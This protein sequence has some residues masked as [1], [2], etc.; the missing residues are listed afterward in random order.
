[1][2][3]NLLCMSTT[4]QTT[5]DIM[6][7]LI[8]TGVI[9]REQADSLR[10]EYALKQQTMLNDKRFRLDG[11][12]RIRPEFRN[13]YQQ[14]RN[15]TT[16]GAMFVAQRSRIT[17]NFNNNDK[18][19]TCLS[20]QDVRVWGQYDPRFSSESSLQLFEAWVEPHLSPNLSMRFGRQ[21]LAYDNQ[22]LFSDNN[23]RTA[24]VSYDALCMKYCDDQLSSDVVVAYNQNSERLRGTDYTPTGF[25]TFKLLL[26]HYL[27]TKLSPG[28]SIS[29]MNVGDAYQDPNSADHLK[30]RFTDGGRL[31]YESGKYYFTAAA[32]YQWGKLQNGKQI[33]AWYFQPE[34]QLRNFYH[35]LIK[36][37]AE[38]FS[39]NKVGLTTIEDHSFVPLYG[40]GHSFNGALDLITKFPSD[41][42]GFGLTNPYLS[43]TYTF[44]PRIE[45]KSELHYFRT[46]QTPVIDKVL[47]RN[48]LS[49]ENDWLAI[50]KPN[51]LLRLEAGC[52]TAIVSEDFERLRKAQAGSH[53]LTPYFVYVSFLVKTELLNILFR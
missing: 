23:W 9:Q 39:G 24:G 10:A 25:N 43:V 1:M 45:L 44:N 37:G 30:M 12:F 13:G 8:G 19:A 14:F 11:E 40:S 26:L 48:F 16:S 51:N 6:N 5:N 34:I 27:H 29:L 41:V 15:D 50:W 32:Y 52:S 18:L 33:K 36:A 2:T 17:L 49:L 35:T 20:F 31:E 22:R 3:F 47:L 46:M 38:F 7:L 53:N 4:A 21:K 28:F 42:G